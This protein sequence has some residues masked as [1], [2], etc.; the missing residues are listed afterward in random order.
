MF[1]DLNPEQRDIVEAEGNVLVTACPG[2]GKTRTLTRKIAYELSKIESSKYI[3]AI[4]FTNRAADEIQK[5]IDSMNIDTENLWTGTVHSFCLEWVLKPYAGYNDKT[6]NG[7]TVIDEFRQESLMNTLKSNYGFKYYDSINTKF[8]RNGDVINSSSRK[9]RLIVDY[10]NHL[11]QNKLIDFDMILYIAYRILL[12][13]PKIA[14]TLSNLFSMFLVDE[15]QDTSDL[16]YAIISKI[17]RSDKGKTRILLV[18]DP[19]QAIFDTLGG[20]AKSLE[21]IINEIGGYPVTHCNLSGN[22]RSSQRIIDLY[23]T[24]QLTNSQITALGK[25]ASEYGNITF[26]DT[27][28]VEELSN[29]IARLIKWNLDNGVPMNEICVIA[30]QWM[31]LVPM[32]RRLKALL[33]D[34]HFDAPGLSPLPRRAENFWFKVAR[35]F[36]TQP[37]P[38]MYLNRIRW[39]TEVV[40]ELNQF[41]GSPIDLSANGLLNL[42]NSIHSK[43]TDGEQFLKESFNK[44]L[45]N[46]NIDLKEHDLLREHYES[47]FAGVKQRLQ[48]ELSQTSM[49]VESF[50]N[51]F[52][53]HKGVVVNTCQGVKG[54]EFETVIAYGLLE[55]LVPHSSL[56]YQSQI[57]ESSS[58]KLLYV[59]CSRAKKN[60]HLIS[61]DGRDRYPEVNKQLN[62]L[63]F[64]FDS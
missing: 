49:G 62:G 15:Y 64:N 8:N 14:E 2:S 9:D 63:Q 34:I 39:A 28:N 58:K 17:I 52:K 29:E 30:P 38:N 51:M 23:R 44:F 40:K 54:E 20:V 33:P 3:I 26:N 25:N 60:L 6:K 42:T 12:E 22:Y 41:I 48:R 21:E 4:T 24:F 10:H 57:A 61:E 37:S 32:A 31:L 45:K 16:Q 1:E 13:K 55:G 35:L 46:L 36:L 18:G 43:K 5:R 27:V 7:F 50:R 59:I 56:K 11:N 19:D 47:F 53:Q